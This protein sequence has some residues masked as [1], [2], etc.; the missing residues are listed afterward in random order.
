MK[1]GIVCPTYFGEGGVYGGAE[2]YVAE[3]CAALSAEAET[4]LI[5]I[6]P[7]KMLRL[8]DGYTPQVHPWITLVRGVRQNALAP[9]ILSSL[10]K[11]DVLHC[12]SYHTVTADLCLLWGRFSGRRCFITDH[13]GGG[14]ISLA[15]WWDAAR[16]SDG[17][18][19]VS[20]FSM[21]RF[22]S[23]PKGSAVVH[24]GVD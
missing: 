1:V 24:G 10:R 23:L 5:S 11:M 7:K 17:I 15:R 13:G 14:D 19:A 2:R 22:R 3:L 16:L 9:S 18:L 8:V 12:H 6:G 21:N 20:R 4:H